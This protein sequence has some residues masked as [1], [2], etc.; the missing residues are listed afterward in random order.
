MWSESVTSFG[1]EPAYLTCQNR[2]KGTF[3][4]WNVVGA[5]DR[6]CSQPAPTPKTPGVNFGGEVMLVG[7][8]F[9]IASVFC[10][11]CG[12]TK[13]MTFGK[14]CVGLGAGASYGP[15]RVY[16][17]GGCNPDAYKG[18]FLEFGLANLTYDL[19]VNEHMDGLSG[20][21][22][23]GAG[24]GFPIFEYSAK[25]GVWCYYWH[26]DTVEF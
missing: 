4:D 12:K 13:M 24:V 8:G 9:G 5:D 15:Q 21:W 16:L 18:W 11:D 14:A 19:G 25:I 20:T 17:S 23:G 1:G 26:L 6:P 2:A 10:N 7:G 3:W 22:E